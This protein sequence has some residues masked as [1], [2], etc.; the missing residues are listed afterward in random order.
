[1]Y[2]L[3]LGLHMPV[4]DCECKLYVGTGE[5]CFVPPKS[6]AWSPKMHDWNYRRS[7]QSR[8]ESLVII[9]WNSTVGEERLEFVGFPTPRAFYVF[10][11][12]HAQH[13]FSDL[14]KNTGQK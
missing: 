11:T 9:H 8:K 5:S 7:R 14:H 12:F 1:M 10:S 3:C 4:D 2:D 13:C 6:S